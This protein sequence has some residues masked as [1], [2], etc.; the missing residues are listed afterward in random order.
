MADKIALIDLGSG[1]M[2]DKSQ[3][4]YVHPKT[5]RLVVETVNTEPTMTD[6]QWKDDCDVNKIVKKYQNTGEFLHRTQKVGRYGDFSEI[7]DYHGMLDTVLK[8]QDA[9]MT[10]PAEV[11]ARFRNDPGYL[12]DFL[13]DPKNLD[14]AV[15]LGL[16]EKRQDVKNANDLTNAT[17]PP[18][19]TPSTDV[20]PK[21]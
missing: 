20:K 13:H 11:R 6:Q 14:E 3:V 16:M 21:S 5:G 19:V 7:Q 12:L 17:T 15:K 18:V 1:D 10:L 4:C 8:A 9:F 2:T